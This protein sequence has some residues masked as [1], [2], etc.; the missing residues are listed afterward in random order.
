MVATV[1]N[2]L[3]S[4][5]KV[6]EPVKNKHPTSLHDY[7]WNS[8]E[9]KTESGSGQH[10]KSEVSEKK[11]EEKVV[12]VCTAICNVTD[13]GDVPVA[14]GT[15]PVC[16]YHK[17]NPNNKIRVY[18]LLDNASGGTFI[19]ED[20]LRRLGVEG[21]ETKL[22]LT[23]MHGTQ[24]VNTKAVD[25]LMASHFREN[26]V[27]VPLPRTYVRQR[28]PADRDE[29]PRP[30]E[31]QEWSY[32]QIHAPPHME[33]VQ[34]GLLLGLNCPSAVRPRDIVC[35]NENEPYAVRSLLGWHVNGPVN[36][37]SSKQTHCNRI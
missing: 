7:S 19:T 28:I 31:L 32:L 23:T 2:T 4:F 15:I 29:I 36:Q 8:E 17:D 13:A 1:L 26:E 35:G 3:P 25:G 18:A 24:E 27:I 20:S 12:N 14:M 11:T 30:E 6:K 33:D 22:L 10:E 9:V 5:A 37:K 34:I 21:S 16:L